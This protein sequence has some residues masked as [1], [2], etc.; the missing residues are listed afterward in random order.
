M[1]AHRLLTTLAIGLA[2]YASHVQAAGPDRIYVGVTLR[3]SVDGRTPPE[4]RMEH[5]VLYPDGIALREVPWGGLDYANVVTFAEKHKNLVGAYTRTEDGMQIEWGV[6]T[7]KHQ[8]WELEASGSGWTR[9]KN[10]TF[11]VADRVDGRMLK[12][13]WQKVSSIKRSTSTPMVGMS[14][15]G[16]YIFRSNGEFEQGKKNGRFELDGYTLVLYDSDGEI[17]RYAIYKW[18]WAAGTIAIETNLYQLVQ[19]RR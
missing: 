8:T 1:S 12:G 5:L 2:L 14:S 13:I 15:G 16:E 18:P 9:G 11:E 19:S 7:R 3:E 17:R 6:G 4:Q 10:T